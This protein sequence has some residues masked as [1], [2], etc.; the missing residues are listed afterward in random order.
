MQWPQRFALESTGQINAYYGNPFHYSERY[1]KDIKLIKK[2]LQV[3]FSIV[4]VDSLCV[5]FNLLIVLYVNNEL[6]K[7]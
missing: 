7:G 3:T 1:L 6:M 4:L 5:P 2:D